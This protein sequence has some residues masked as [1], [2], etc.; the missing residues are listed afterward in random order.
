MC[1]N[2]RSPRLRSLWKSS[3][4]ACA[5]VPWARR[6]VR[7]LTRPVACPSGRTLFE[8]NDAIELP[9]AFIVTPLRQAIS[10]SLI[11]CFREDVGQLNG[12]LASADLQPEVLRASYTASELAFPSATRA[13]MTHR[14]AWQIAAEAPG[15]TLI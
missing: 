1:C 13:L 9:G 6:A 14:R 4:G 10:R 12:A 11:V 15:Y 7:S 5:T 8:S 2:A 3:T